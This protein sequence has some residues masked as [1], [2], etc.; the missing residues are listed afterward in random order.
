MGTLPFF[1]IPEKTRY[2]HY[3]NLGSIDAITDG[4]GNIVGDIGDA[5]LFLHP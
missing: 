4:Q 2:L 1:Y 5:T 3:D